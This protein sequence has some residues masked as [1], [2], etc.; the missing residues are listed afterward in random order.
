MK[1]SHE[2]LHMMHVLQRYSCVI[3]FNF[4]LFGFLIDY[5][6]GNTSC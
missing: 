5:V 1:G 3:I 2:R 4:F 6:Q